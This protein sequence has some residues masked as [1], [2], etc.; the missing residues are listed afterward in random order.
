MES[1]L[2]YVD[3]DEVEKRI[4]KVKGNRNVRVREVNMDV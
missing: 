2:R 1:G 3:N 4:L